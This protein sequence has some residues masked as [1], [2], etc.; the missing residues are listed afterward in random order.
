M[1]NESN[2]DSDEASVI[3]PEKPAVEPEMDKAVDEITKHDSDEL[4]KAEDAKHEAAPAPKQVWYKKLLDNKKVAI[5]SAI[6]L[7]L[8]ILMAIPFT[9]YPI[10][11]TFLKDNY[12]L[13]VWD[14]Q[15]NQPV[16][17]ATVSLAGATATTDNHGVAHL[18]VKVGRHTLVVTKKYYTTL[19]T[20]V[21]VP[22]RSHAGTTPFQ[23]VATGRQV[24]V[25]V[26]NKINGKP[27]NDATVKAADTEAH[28]DKNGQVTV[29]LPADKTSVTATISASGYNNS[30][31]TVQVTTQAVKAN[32]FQLTPAGKIYFLSKLSGKIDVVKT[33]LDGTGRQTVLAGTGNEDD[34]GT[35]LLAS[36]DWKFL[37]LQAVRQAGASAE[38][39]L[40]DTSND[41]LTNIDKGDAIFNVTGWQNHNFIYTVT[42]NTVP[43]WQSNQEALKSFNADNNKLTTLDQTT[44][45][46]NNQSDFAA[47]SLDNVFI[48]S[49]A[50]VYTKDWR[51]TNYS[52]TTDRLN[53]KQAEIISVQSDGSKRTTLKTASLPAGNNGFD[54]GF[55][56]R[57]YEPN[58]IYFQDAN[59]NAFYKYDD[60]K[61]AA[62]NDVD[63]NSFYQ[64]VY[65]YYLVSPSGKQAFWS[66]PR[67]GKNTLFV[68]GGNGDNGKQIASLSDYNVYGW[69]TDDYLLVFK[70]SSELYIMPVAGGTPIKITDYHK[71]AQ[72]FNAYGGR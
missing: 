60:G 7:L 35:V 62:T 40:I 66:E 20:K 42:R 9:R 4:L 47:N 56:A 63:E 19:S 28:T 30:S 69:Y 2:K 59:N 37:A 50:I 6:V 21:L 67:D 44:A 17:A 72:Q 65:N 33:N 43:V 49:D 70:N 61:L 58:G 3:K 57:L 48:V 64:K 36:P 39:D 71:P 31:A 46:G 14:S 68:G 29:V 38:L 41:Q 27:I 32:D 11:G 53:G 22:L 8:L 55:N 26:T 5:P 25:T 34:T 15:S 18:K 51:A 10:L 52:Y 24:P 54:L 13:T 16:S 23:V 12:A 45:E 1:N